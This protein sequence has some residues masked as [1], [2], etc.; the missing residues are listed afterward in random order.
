LEV[1]KMRLLRSFLTLSLSFSILCLSFGNSYSEEIWWNDYRE[2]L[3]NVK[4]IHDESATIHV[5]IPENFIANKKEITLTVTIKSNVYVG[6]ALKREK[7]FHLFYPSISVN[8]KLF[9]SQR[10]HVTDL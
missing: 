8:N 5:E 10:I 6:D 9:G 1:G 7:G 4:V 2:P 3:Y